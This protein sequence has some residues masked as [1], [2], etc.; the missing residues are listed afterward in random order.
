[1]E[2]QMIDFDDFYQGSLDYYKKPK[3]AEIIDFK[4][5]Q[6]QVIDFTNKQPT[7]ESN[8]SFSSVYDSIPAMR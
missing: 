6:P 2:Q 5:V 1:M 3:Q 7:I 4:D 8:V